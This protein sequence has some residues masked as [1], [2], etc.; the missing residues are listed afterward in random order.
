MRDPQ[1]Q[2]RGISAHLE[3]RPPPPTKES[4]HTETHARMFGLSLGALLAACL[5]LNAMSS[6]TRLCQPDR[7][8]GGTEC[9]TNQSGQEPGY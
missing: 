2:Y 6:S 3:D 5:F 4:L 9:T 8:D 1:I 7:T